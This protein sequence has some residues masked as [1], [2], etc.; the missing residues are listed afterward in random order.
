MR[1]LFF[2]INE[3]MLSHY[4][5]RLLDSHGELEQLMLLKGYDWL[6]RPFGIARTEQ[7]VVIYDSIF[8]ELMYFDMPSSDY[9]NSMLFSPD[10]D[11]FGIGYYDAFCRQSQ[12]NCI[13]FGHC[14]GFRVP[15]QL[16]GA[17]DASNLELYEVFTYWNYTSIMSAILVKIPDGTMLK[18]MRLDSDPG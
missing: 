13:P 17:V 1:S 8:D 5:D 16:G 9:R 4:S 11:N 3:D 15:P 12:L 10:K 18:D 2:F 7:S 6:G 14:A